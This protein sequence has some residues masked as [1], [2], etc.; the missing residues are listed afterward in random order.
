MSETAENDATRVHEYEIRATLRI[1]LRE[2]APEDWLTRVTQPGFPYARWN[3]EPMSAADGLKMLA[4]NAAAN[5]VDDASRLDG[6][7]DLER[8][9]VTLEVCDVEEA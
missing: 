7:G 4:H 6:W 1:E 2:D 8:G 5:G 3:G 9:M